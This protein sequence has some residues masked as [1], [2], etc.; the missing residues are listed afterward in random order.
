MLSAFHSILNGASEVII[1]GKSYKVDG[2]HIH[3]EN[4]ATYFLRRASDGSGWSMNEW[5]LHEPLR[6]MGW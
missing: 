4:G 1:N 5:E 3:Y 2:R 6:F